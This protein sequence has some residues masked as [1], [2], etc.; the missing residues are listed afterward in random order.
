LSTSPDG[1]G[2]SGLTKAIGK[3][4][5]RGLNGQGIETYEQL[6]GFTESQLLE[7]HGVG[8]RAIGILREELSK[9]SLKF[10]DG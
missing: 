7:I 8:P 9:R 3:P 6:A 4:A 2:E 10:A 5:T 1:G